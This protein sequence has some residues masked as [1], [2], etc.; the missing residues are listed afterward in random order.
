MSC[1]ALFSF[2][3]GSALAAGNL[4]KE[5]ADLDRV[6]IAAL[7][8]T[9]ADNKVMS[10]KVIKVLETNWFAFAKRHLRDFPDD[11]STKVDFTQINQMIDDAAQITRLNGKLTEV[12]EILAGVRIIFFHLRQRNSIDYYLDHL[13]KF[14]ESLAPITEVTRNKTPDTLSAGNI[15]SLNRE[16]SDLSQVWNEAVKAHF[17]P[18]VFSF[19]AQMNAKRKEYITAETEALTRLQQALENENKAAIIQAA[20]AVSDNFNKLYAS[21]GSTEGIK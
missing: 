17:D 12:H 16:I 10:K 1:T 3:S 18:A 15:A 7:T 13:L 8:V 9:A 6:Y 21:F 11:N 20:A 14:D 19:T 4:E 5:M 2:P